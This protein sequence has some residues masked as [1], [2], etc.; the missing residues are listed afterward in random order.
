MG[1][2]WR[3][4]KDESSFSR[5]GKNIKVFQDNVFYG[6]TKRMIC[7]ADGFYGKVFAFQNGKNGFAAG[8][9]RSFNESIVD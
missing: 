6:Q 1:H 2:E 7:M 5:F 8:H 4:I 9:E 3:V